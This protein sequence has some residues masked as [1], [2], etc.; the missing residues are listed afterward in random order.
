M[1]RHPV[2][3]APPQGRTIAVVVPAEDHAL[4]CRADAGGR[5]DQRLQS[6]ALDFDE[7]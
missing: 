5:L 3:N 2:I 4:I 7:F 6:L 1:S